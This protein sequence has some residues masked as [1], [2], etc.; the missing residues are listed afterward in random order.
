MGTDEIRIV[1]AVKPVPGRP[2]DDAR[3]EEAVAVG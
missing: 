1:A 2:A 3:A